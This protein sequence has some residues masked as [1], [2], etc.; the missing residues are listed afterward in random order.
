[1]R[2]TKS[3]AEYRGCD[4]RMH[5][6]PSPF[7]V[8]VRHP[9]DKV[10]LLLGFRPSSGLPNAL[11]CLIETCAERNENARRKCAAA[12]NSGTAVYEDIPSGPDACGDL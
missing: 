11:E 1:M 4:H 2:V 10:S 5:R 8:R 6:E 9:A 3:L 7:I 12:A